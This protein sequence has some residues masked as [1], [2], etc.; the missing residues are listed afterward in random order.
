[1]IV[2]MLDCMIHIVISVLMY[3]SMFECMIVDDVRISVNY[4]M[5]K[6][7][8]SVLDNRPYVYDHLIGL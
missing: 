5:L 4:M 8:R 6:L 7:G 3:G 1:M 2:N